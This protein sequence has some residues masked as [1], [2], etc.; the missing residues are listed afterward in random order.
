MLEGAAP[1]LAAAKRVARPALTAGGLQQLT[2]AL[3]AAALAET[4]L[5]RVVTRVGVH[6]PKSHGVTDAFQAASFLGSVAFNFASLLAIALV[7]LLLAAMVIR[8]RNW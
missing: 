8:M 7:A 1:R 5:L 3:L 2:A 4:L 6:L